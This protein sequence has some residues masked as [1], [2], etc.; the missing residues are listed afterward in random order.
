MRKAACGLFL[1]L[2]LVGAADARQIY[3]DNLSGDDRLNGSQPRVL[4]DGSGPVRTLAK[5]LRVAGPGDLIQLGPSKQPYR[6]SVSLVGNRLSGTVTRPLVLDGNGA[7]LDGSAQVPAEQW[8]FYRDNRFRFSPPRLAHYQLFLDDRPAVRVL[9]AA[10]SDS[11]PKLQPRQWCSH[12]GYIYFAVE[13]TKLP[14]DY[15]LSYACLPTGITLYHVERVIIKDLT[16]R[17]FQADGIAAPDSARRITLKGVTA[18]SNGRSGLS[19]GGAS[20]VDIDSCQ[21]QGNGVAQLLTL[22]YSEIHIHNSRLLGDT[23]PAWLDQGGRVYLGEERIQ[24]G[25][26]TIENQAPRPA[27]PPT[28]PA[29]GPAPSAKEPAP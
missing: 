5:A 15:A 13:P 11:P 10:T 29:A 25:R 27:T 3:V 26:T 14:A 18:A 23:A 2:L 24:G 19:V 16:V 20:Q 12:Q 4:P 6:E 17:G 9:A 21:L 7:V 1:G 28:A 22:P 8:K